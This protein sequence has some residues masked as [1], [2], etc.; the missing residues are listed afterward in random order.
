MW[1]RSGSE[2]SQ[3][4]Q[5][6][7]GGGNDPLTVVGDAELKARP[8]PGYP[9]RQHCHRNAWTK[10]DHRPFSI[11]RRI[12][13][14]RPSHAGRRLARQAPTKCTRHYM[15]TG[16]ASKQLSCPLIEKLGVGHQ[17]DDECWLRRMDRV[18][19]DLVREREYDLG[20]RTTD[21]SPAE[22]LKGGLD[23]LQRDI[24]PEPR[25]EVILAAG[26]GG[27]VGSAVQPSL[28]KR[29]AQL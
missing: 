28:C 20:A 13:F 29:S 7:T 25:T 21:R 11:E 10:R 6:A 1:C 8:G 24:E 27:V 12:L 18:S 17:L 16:Q 3:P 15:S 26:H 4:S 22:H 23:F 9:S 19:E 14:P 2:R 5:Q